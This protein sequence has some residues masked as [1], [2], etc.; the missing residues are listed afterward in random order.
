MWSNNVRLFVV[1]IL[2]TIFYYGAMMV[3]DKEGTVVA[4]ISRVKI[5]I[6]KVVY[7]KVP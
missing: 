5:C 3:R 4:E 2:P 7:F 1:D 6:L